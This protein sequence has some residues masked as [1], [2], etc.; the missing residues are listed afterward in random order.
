VWNSPP[1]NL[2]NATMHTSSSTA[3]SSPRPAAASSS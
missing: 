2:G 3:A 1:Q